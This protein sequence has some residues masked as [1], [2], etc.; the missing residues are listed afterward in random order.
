M[1][2]LIVLTIT[3]TIIVVLAFV[4]LSKV[5]KSSEV[6]DIEKPPIVDNFACS[7]YCPGP[8]EKYM[9]KIYQGVEDD[10]ECRKLG[11]RPSSYTGWGTFR[12]CIA[13]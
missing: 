4:F 9:V 11:G 7:D 12:I 8:R 2:K 3:A 13:E 6:T 1:K 10:E 5:P